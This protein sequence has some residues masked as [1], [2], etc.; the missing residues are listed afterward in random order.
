MM[1]SRQSRS[2]RQT[3]A[4]GGDE[5]G[6]KQPMPEYAND[7]IRLSPAHL[8]PADFRQIDAI[9]GPEFHGEDASLSWDFYRRN[10]NNS[11]A[12]LDEV[13]EEVR[14]KKGVAQFKVTAE[15][16]EAR[17]TLTGDDDGC[18]LEF[19]SS[20]AA[21]GNVLQKVHAISGLFRERKRVTAHLPNVQPWMRRPKLAVG[22]PSLTIM[23][24]RDE[25]IQGVITRW[26][27]MVLGLP[28]SFLGGLITGV[29]AF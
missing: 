21:H 5:R 19:E 7:T 8:A 11:S 17:I 15:N 14:D 25:I 22:Q 18:W 12:N 13:L 24:S 9:L 6:H 1:C 4:E 29:V 26:L 2:E 3:N 20:E 23:L 10:R 27:A 16:D 28:L